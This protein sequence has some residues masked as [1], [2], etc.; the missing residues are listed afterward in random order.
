MASSSSPLVHLLRAAILMV[1]LFGTGQAAAAAPWILVDTAAST[2]Q[3]M[4]GEKPVLTLEHIAVGRAGI[5][6]LHVKGDDRTPLGEFRVTRIDHRSRYR[7]FIGIDYPTPAHVKQA[8]EQGIIDQATH[9]K[10]VRDTKRLGTPPQNT[11]LGGHIGLHGLGAG[12][13]KVHDQFN[14]TH[15][16]VALTNHQIDQLSRWVRIGTRVVIK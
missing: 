3:V 9:D 4:R 2:A 16:C 13:P 12:D 15:G 10:I 7:L 6:P 8:L 11:V 1:A 14:W 5:T